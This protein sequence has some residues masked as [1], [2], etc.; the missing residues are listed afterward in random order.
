[1]EFHIW[2]REFH[3]WQMEFYIWHRDYCTSRVR[4]NVINKSKSLSW[5]C[6][7]R[8][9]DKSWAQWFVSL[10]LWYVSKELK[11]RMIIFKQNDFSPFF[12][13]TMPGYIPAHFLWKFWLVKWYGNGYWLIKW[14]G[15]G[16]WLVKWYGNGKYWLVK[17]YGNGK[18]WLVKWC[19]N[20]WRAWICGSEFYYVLLFSQ[21][22]MK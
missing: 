7:L 11:T 21:F 16:Y 5:C 8:E 17:W 15:N 13:F 14:Y 10:L 9:R 18:Y 22:N 12:L 1:M 3:I 19:G 2:H 20:G 4:K 6:F